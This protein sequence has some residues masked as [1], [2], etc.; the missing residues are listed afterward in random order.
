[1]RGN[2]VAKSDSEGRAVFT[3]SLTLRFEGENV[4][5]VQ[6]LLGYVSGLNSA[7]QACLNSEYHSPSMKLQVVAIQK[8]SFEL[9]LQG[10]V[11]LAPDL[12]THIPEVI[13]S[14]KT[15]M[16]IIKLKRDLKGQKPQ[17]VENEGRQSKITNHE[18]EV[19]YYDCNVA[20]IYINNPN[21]DDGLTRAF[22]ALQVTS[23]RNAVH[24]TSGAESLVVGK[25]DY[26]NMSKPIVSKTDDNSMQVNAFETQLRIRKL[27][28]IGD[29]MW[30][31]VDNNN[32][33]LT[34]TIEDET[35][36]RKVKAGEIK[37]SAND[38][39]YVRLR[40][41]ASM[42]KYM[43]VKKRKYYIEAVLNYGSPIQAEQLSIPFPE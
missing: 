20:N 34:A 27:D 18:G 35:F 9:V 5:D 36:S 2:V 15:L 21:V 28:F 24:F 8:G 11:A 29:T 33:N 10:I 42:D 6:E 22:S 16:D 14:F 12:L 40:V 37:L 25:D 3:D 17:K 26:S 41:E 23:P 31:F 13:S 32:R 7:Y 4:I 19:T 38:V 1:M 43:N 30:S 39:L